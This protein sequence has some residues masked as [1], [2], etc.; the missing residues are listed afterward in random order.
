MKTTQRI[1]VGLAAGAGAAALA[2]GG[3]AARTWL[4]YGE[5]GVQSP[6][7]RFL[8]NAEIR[9]VHQADVHAPADVAFDVARKVDIGQSPIVRAIFTARA[10]FMGA[11][12]ADSPPEPFLDQILRIGWGVL[13]ETPHREIVLGAVCKPWEA[14]VKF[15]AIPVQEFAAFSEPENVKIV[16]NLKT[17]PI[18]DDNARVVID[19]IAAATGPESRRRFRKYWALV[20]PGVSLIRMESLRL[21]KSDAEREFRNAT[22]RAGVTG[23]SAE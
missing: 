14:D 17:E 1:G 10:W 11:A 4:R 12:S 16:W 2:Y 7:A 3:V 9:E 13:E 18:D 5:P 21:M 20:S 22:L 15:R 19:T 23:A 8:P 6:L